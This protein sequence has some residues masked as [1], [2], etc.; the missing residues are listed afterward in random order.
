MQLTKSDF[1][2]CETDKIGEYKVGLNFSKFQQVVEF[3]EKYRNDYDNID[4]MELLL[5]EQKDIYKIWLYYEDDDY[6]KW[7]FNYCFKDGLK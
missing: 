2:Q 1:E 4:G 6:N 5:K 7:L 3:Y